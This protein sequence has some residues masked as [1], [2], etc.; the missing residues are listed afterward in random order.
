M[1]FPL[2]RVRPT[3]VCPSRSHWV[4]MSSM[5]LRRSSR[6]PR[7]RSMRWLAT[8]MPTLWLVLRPGSTSDRA[9]SLDGD[10][11]LVASQF[12]SRFA[13][14]FASPFGGVGELGSLA[15]FEVHRVSFVVGG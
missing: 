7:R 4:P 8:L 6:R 9:G 1:P 10:V 13:S 15:S 2:V 3:T 14:Q 11:E 12:A 5:K